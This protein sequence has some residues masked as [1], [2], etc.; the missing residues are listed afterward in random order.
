MYILSSDNPPEEP[1]VQGRGG[2]TDPTRSSPSG[3]SPM[4]GLAGD[5]WSRGE[6]W[7]CRLN[8]SPFPESGQH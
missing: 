5:G 7:G 2:R 4:S 6:P 3:P 1:K 8:Q